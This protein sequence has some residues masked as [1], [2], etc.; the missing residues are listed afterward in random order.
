MGIYRLSQKAEADLIEIYMIG[1]HQFGD[2]QAERYH[3]AFEKAFAFL[4]D[5]PRAARERAEIDPPVRVHPR[6]SHLIIY[7]IEDE[8]IVILRIRHSREDWVSAPTGSHE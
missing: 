2:A 1:V 5:Y 7:E 4:A 6:G 8:D 3:A